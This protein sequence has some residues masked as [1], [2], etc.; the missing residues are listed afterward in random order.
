MSVEVTEDDVNEKDRRA[1]RVLL[2]ML[3]IRRGGATGMTLENMAKAEAPFELAAEVFG[4]HR[5]RAEVRGEIRGLRRCA[6][7]TAGWCA[8]VKAAINELEAELKELSR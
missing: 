1:A 7:M 6:E 8:E 2:P 5:R 4:K 3:G